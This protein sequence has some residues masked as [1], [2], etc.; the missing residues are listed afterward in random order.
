MTEIKKRKPSHFDSVRVNVH[1][2]RNNCDQLNKP[3]DKEMMEI[4]R[5]SHRSE[6]WSSCSPSFSSR[7]LPR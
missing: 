1:G 6:P 3:I 7:T 4:E 2:K 5:P